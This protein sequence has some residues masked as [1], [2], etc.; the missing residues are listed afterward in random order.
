MDQEYDVHREQH[1]AQVAL[2]N[3]NF[4]PRVESFTQYLIRFNE[5]ADNA[6]PGRG[7]EHVDE[8]LFATLPQDIRSRLLADHKE[9]LGQE[10]LREYIIRIADTLAPREEYNNP[11]SH[12]HQMTPNDPPGQT[13]QMH[14]ANGKNIFNG[15]CYKCNN[16]GHRARDC[17]LPQ[18]PR[19]G[20]KQMSQ[21]AQA[22]QQG[23]QNHAN[24][25]NNNYSQQGNNQNN[26]NQ[27]I[28]HPPGQA[29]GNARDRSGGHKRDVC[30]LGGKE[31]HTAINCFQLKKL[32]D[33]QQKIPYQK[34]STEENRNY[35]KE[36]KNAQ[37]PL[38]EMQ[39]EQTEYQNY[40]NQ[41]E[42]YPQEYYQNDGNQYSSAPS[43]N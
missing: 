39:Y 28:N 32:A 23:R 19:P 16:F 12:L 43:E 18:P 29:W 34:Q 4:N 20:F 11:M 33:A 22:V 25:Q 10:E 13:Q 35:R 2:H 9:K 36:F 5:L 15:N 37:R 40:D 17:K 30:Q 7:Q 14:N 6:F 3:M 26:Q 24:N 8:M 42:T 1:R 31:G 41:Q 38:N 21:H 27:K